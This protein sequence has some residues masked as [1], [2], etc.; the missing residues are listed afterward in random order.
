M[1]DKRTDLVES[2][3]CIYCGKPADEHC[4]F[5]AAKVPEGCKCDYRAWGEPPP[6]ICERFAG[7]HESCERCAHE[8]GCHHG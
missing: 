7:D 8:K 1:A 5:E 6:P 2:D 3:Q 4:I